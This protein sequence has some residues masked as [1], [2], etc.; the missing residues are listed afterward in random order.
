MT[1]DPYWRRAIHPSEHP[2]LQY[3]DYQVEPEPASLT[4]GTSFLAQ[5]VY[6]K[7]IVCVLGSFPTVVAAVIAIEEHMQLRLA[8]EG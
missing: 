3:G 1:N 6:G 2:L 7:R 5:Q 4:E 8:A